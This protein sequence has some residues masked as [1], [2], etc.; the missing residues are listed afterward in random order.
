MRKEEEGQE[1]REGGKGGEK[2]GEERKEGG[3]ERDGG[4][5]GGQEGRAW[6]LDREFS[7]LGP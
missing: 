2:E 1:E 3:E 7:G 5:A 6:K 4:R